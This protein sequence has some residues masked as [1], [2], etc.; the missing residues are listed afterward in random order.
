MRRVAVGGLADRPDA[1]L[2]QVREQAVST[3]VGG[4]ADRAGTRPRRARSAR[5]R[6]CPGGTRG[7]GPTGRP[8]AG[9]GSPARPGRGVRRPSGVS[10]AAPAT[11]TA[12]A[13]RRRS[14]AGRGGA[15]RRAAGWGAGTVSSPSVCARS[16]R[17]RR[18]ASR[19]GAGNVRRRM[20]RPARVPSSGRRRPGRAGSRSR[21]SAA[22]PLIHSALISTALPGRGVTAMPVDHRVHPGQRL[23][24]GALGEQPVGR[25]DPD[26][27][28]GAGQ[29]RGDHAVERVDQLGGQVVVAGDGEVPVDR[30][31]EP[32]RRVGGV[33]LRAARCRP[34]WRASPPRAWPRSARS[35]AAP[36]RP[37]RWSGT[38]P[39]RRSSCRATTRRTTGSPATTSGPPAVVTMNASAASASASS[40]PS[41]RRRGRRDRPVARPRPATTCAAG[42]GGARQVA[43][44]ARTPPGL[45]R[46]PASLANRPTQQQVLVG[47]R[48]RAA[49]SR[50]CTPSH[51]C[52]SGAKPGPA[53][54][55]APADHHAV[56][57]WT[58]RPAPRRRRGAR[59]ARRARCTAAPASA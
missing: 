10:R 18:G 46:A 56:R 12:A 6:R 52:P 48:P 19:P 43:G 13:R 58:P 27:V 59:R 47:G 38:G 24:L 41:P 23:A 28:A 35:S 8:G 40:T 57:L 49:S 20:P 42:G 4:Q 30:V 25:V 14:A 22:S 55:Y 1:P 34:C 31:Q 51:Q 53:I 50:W 39:R 26:A 36:P 15:R 3:P 17:S 54:R 32:Q 5:A 16:S 33:V 2:G 7:R 37:G 21:A 44:P 9:P 11:R 29:V 45:A